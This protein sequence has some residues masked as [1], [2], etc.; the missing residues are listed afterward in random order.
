MYSDTSGWFPKNDSMPTPRQAR[1]PLTRNS[2]SQNTKFIHA[3][4]IEYMVCDR[5]CQVTTKKSIVSPVACGS[6]V[7][8]SNK[9][10]TGLFQNLCFNAQSGREVE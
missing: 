5:N 7:L 10:N 2:Y 3:G 8:D 9:R 1:P 4:S 6:A